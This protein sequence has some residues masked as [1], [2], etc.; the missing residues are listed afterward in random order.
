MQS[1]ITTRMAVKQAAGLIRSDADPA[2]MG[3]ILVG[4]Y[5]GFARRMVE[6]KERPDLE[7]WL[8]SFTEILYDG[9]L[10]RP[11]KAMPPRPAGRALPAA[12]GGTAPPS[13][14]TGSRKEPR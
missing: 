9:M 12:R 10:E 3:D 13:L 7:G 5:E 6:L 14:T 1:F 11:R 4:T 2:V 8:R